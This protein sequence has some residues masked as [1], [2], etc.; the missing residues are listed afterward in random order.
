MAQ[1]RAAH[2][3]VGIAAAVGD[4]SPAVVVGY[5]PGDGRLCLRG[6]ETRSLRGR[7]SAATRFD[8]RQQVAFGDVQADAVSSASYIN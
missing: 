2:A 3:E 7:K 8:R 1:H 6:R 5:G 4:H